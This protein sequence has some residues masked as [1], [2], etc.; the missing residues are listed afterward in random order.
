M[1]MYYGCM[2][3]SMIS[4]F[5]KHNAWSYQYYGWV[6]CF[7]HRSV[8]TICGRI[9]VGFVVDVVCKSTQH[10]VVSVNTIYCRIM[11]YDHALCLLND[12][13]IDKAMQP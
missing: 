9:M 1:W 12:D 4:S 8:K 11:G 7:C 5:S 3:L 10:V 2:A 6:C 13:I